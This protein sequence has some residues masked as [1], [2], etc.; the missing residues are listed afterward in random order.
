VRY[1]RQPNS[2]VRAARNL[3]LAAAR[4]E[5]IAFLDSDD[6]WRP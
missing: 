6:T 1:L 2:G 4:G 5:F 3:G